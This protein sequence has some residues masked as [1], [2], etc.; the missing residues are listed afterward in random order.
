MGGLGRA[1][2]LSGAATPTAGR[3]IAKSTILIWLDGGASH[4]DTWDM[5]PAAPAQIRGEFPTIATSTSGIT[6]CEHLPLLARQTQH[7]AIVQSATHAL[8]NEL[9]G[10]N[11]HASGYYHGLTAHP[12]DRS[13]FIGEARRSQPDDDPFIGSVVAAK[14]RLHPSL[15]QLVMLPR[16]FRVQDDTAGQY[17]TVLGSDYDPMVVYGS[18]DQPP[19]FTV[20]TLELQA[21]VSPGRL[22]ARRDLLDSLD[23]SHRKLDELAA[24]NT[25]SKHQQRAFSLLYSPQTKSAFDIRREPVS[26]LR[27]YGA[28]VNAMSM[29]M[30]RRLVEA[31]V[32]F[33]TVVWKKEDPELHKKT[34]CNGTGSWDTHGKNFVCLKEILLPNFD[35]MFAALLDD[36]HERGLLDDTLVVVNSEMGRKPRIGDS[37][38]GGESGRDHWRQC[39]SV[40]LAGGGIRGGRLYGSSDRFAEYPRDKPVTPADLAKTIYYAMGIDN[41]DAVDRNGKPIRLLEEGRPIQELF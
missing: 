15:P 28:G 36:L 17:A 26:T 22:I 38:L 31:G 40:L 11:N 41:L 2:S 35:R 7:L 1:A 32:P 4:I 33:V 23:R 8:G 13:F 6:L 27:K 16:K 14:R 9:Q 21:E 25:F 34:F 29:L 18:R 5:K 20:P 3:K 39:M 12:P 24:T 19:R 30:A 37:R 10:P